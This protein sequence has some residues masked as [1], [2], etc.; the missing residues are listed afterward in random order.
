MADRY[1]S[2]FGPTRP[3][4][5]DAPEAFSFDELQKIRARRLEVDLLHAASCAWPEA[6]RFE[7][8]RPGAPARGPTLSEPTESGVRLVAS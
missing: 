8:I 7:T 6:R 2:F 3:V 4:S 5:A 1:P